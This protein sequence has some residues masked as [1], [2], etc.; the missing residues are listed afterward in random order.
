MPIGSQSVQSMIMGTLTER[1]VSWV[2]DGFE[3]GRFCAAVQQHRCED[4][5]LMPALAQRLAAFDTSGYDLSP[6][7]RIYIT[8][9]A[10]P[11]ATLTRL[12]EQFEGCTVLNVYGTTESWPT[13]LTSEFDLSRPRSIGKLTDPSMVRI[14]DSDG[15]PVPR[16]ARGDVQ[17]RAGR[18]DVGGRGYLD[19]DTGEL[20]SSDG[21]VITGDIGYVDEDG[22]IF[23]VDRSIRI[24]QTY[25]DKFSP[26]EVEFALTEHP[27]VS[28]AA[29]FDVRPEGGDQIV[30]GAV[31]CSR[32]DVTDEELRLHLSERVSKFMIPDRFVRHETLPLT[33]AR[34]VDIRRL[35]GD[36]AAD[37][38]ITVEVDS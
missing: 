13:F 1:V 37:E 2:L 6:M 12:A 36:W 30:V 5:L 20:S 11:P 25:E 8:G 34:K 9:A 15:D 23:V 28:A 38:G 33:P 21:W 32:P 10:T 35:A 29:V 18:E 27:A 24:I 31:V 22:F 17:L 4:T 19:I 26:L 14:V 7:R 16:G 3:P